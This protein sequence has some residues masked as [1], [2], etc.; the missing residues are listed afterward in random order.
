MSTPISEATI[1]EWIIDY[2][3]NLFA[4]P[5]EAIDTRQPFAA[6]GLD[7]AAAA[8]MSGDLADWLGIDMDPALPYDFVNT[9]ELAGEV[10]R[11]ARSQQP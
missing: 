8:A 4:L 5:R 11:I 9:E 3:A 2:L 6:L 1:R 10:A 7:S